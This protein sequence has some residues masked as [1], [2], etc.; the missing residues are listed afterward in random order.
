LRCFFIVGSGFVKEFEQSGI[1]HR[2]SAQDLGQR[3][4]R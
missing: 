4:V 1:G 3:C 2:L